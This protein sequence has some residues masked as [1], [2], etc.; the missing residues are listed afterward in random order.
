MVRRAAAPR[1]WLLHPAASKGGHERKGSPLAYQWTFTS[2]PAG[3]TAVIDLPSA[4][5]PTFFADRVG[6]Y[7]ATLVVNDGVLDS[8]PQSVTIAAV[9][10]EIPIIIANSKGSFRSAVG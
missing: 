3:S 5:S 1:V 7:V 4:D 2:V 9:D 10:A 6:V 8:L